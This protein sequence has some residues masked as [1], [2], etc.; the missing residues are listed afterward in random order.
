MKVVLIRHGEADYSNLKDYSVARIGKEIA[1]LSEK[2]RKQAEN[3]SNDIRLEG[4][5]IVITS[6]FTRALET[7]AIIA[8]NRN[9]DIKV[10]TDLHEW[11]IEDDN[12]IKYKELMGRILREAIIHKGVHTEDCEFY[13]EDFKDITERALNV[14]KKYLKYDKITVVTHAGVIKQLK[15]KTQIDNC[16]IIELEVDKDSKF[17][18]FYDPRVLDDDRKIRLVEPSLEYEEKIFDYKERVL[19]A[20]GFIH[21]SSNLENFSNLNE[22]LKYMEELKNEETCPEGFVPGT[23]YLAINK[24]DKLVGMI[25]IRKR[26]NENLLKYDGHIGYSILPSERNHGYGTEL[27]K[28]AIIL[29]K[30]EKFDRL[31]VTCDENNIYSAKVIENNG[32]VLEN[33]IAYGNTHRKRY[34]IDLELNEDIKLVRPT[35][36]YKEQIEEYKKE[37]FDENLYFIEGSGKLHEFKDIEEWIKNN[38]LMSSEES[39]D[40]DF[41]PNRTFLAIRESDDKLIGMANLR[42]RLKDNPENLNGNIVYSVRRS[43]RQ[44]GYSKKIL[45]FALEKFKDK[46]N[47]EALITCDKDNIASVKAI[48][49][50]G[51]KLIEELRFEGM[52]IQKYL[53]VL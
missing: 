30:R 34:W 16:E 1:P 25:N 6:P 5:E 23:T 22:W 48:V 37:F 52:T 18:G 41:V 14:I 10:E 24:E 35:I 36:R 47:D 38:E 50:N 28:E 32:G 15:Y 26:L 17:Q 44:K 12:S 8:K 46:G 51:G 39:Y 27:L 13:W 4:A 2:G 40:R 42:Y 31:L 45:K 9:I 3:V 19:Q 21:G 49:E 11:I 53:I 29:C 43:E 20:D 33:R 7:A